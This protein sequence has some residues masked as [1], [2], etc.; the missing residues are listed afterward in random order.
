MVFGNI[1]AFWLLLA[2][3]FIAIIG[4]WGWKAKQEIIRV[5]VTEKKAKASQ[6]RKYILASIMAII[7]IFAIAAPRIPVFLPANTEKEGL[8]VFLVDVSGSMAAQEELN[9][10]N[11]LE[12]VKQMLP[13]IIDEFPEATFYPF[14]FTN[15]ARSVTPPLTKE[16]FPYLKESI[17]NILD[18]YSAPGENSAFGKPILQA[19]SKIAKAEKVKIIVLFSDG[20]FKTW[21][22]RTDDANL[23]QALGK[24]AQEN[25]KIITV[26][27]GEKDG[28]KIPLYDE[29]G[30]FTGEFASDYDQPIITKLKEERLMLIASRTQ[31]EYFPEKDF[32][33]MVDFLSKNLESNVAGNS[34]K[35]IN[36][37]LMI[38]AAVLWIIFARLYLR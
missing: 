31:G 24:A 10:P 7:V 6:I 3:I 5:W 15:T 21:G 29:A 33:G 30:E 4:L 12:R 19:V 14:H 20:E 11:R 2:V 8:I 36:Y 38:P 1:A 25:V 9:S 22:T 35:D 27:V 34:Y 28:A 23:E 37:F 16:D 17:D 18:I 13:E 26:G 32:Q